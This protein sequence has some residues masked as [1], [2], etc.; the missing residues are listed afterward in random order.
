MLIDFSKAPTVIPEFFV[1][2]V[3][4]KRVAEHKYLGKV[5]DNKLNFN[6]NSDFIHK[7]CQTRIFCLLKLRSL[8]INAAVL[9]TFYRCCIESVLNIFVSVLVWRLE[10]E[11]QECLN[12]VVKVCGKVVGER[13]EH[14]SKLY[15]C[16]VVRKV[17]VIV[18]DNSHVLAK[19][20]EFLPS[21]RRFRVPKSNTVRN[22]SQQHF[23]TDKFVQIYNIV[24][25]GVVN[26]QPRFNFFDD[27]I[28]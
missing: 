6:K 10:Y 19:Y 28:K 8:N 25:C 1:D 24:Y 4:G 16:R 12:K 27:I 18:D 3:K 17:G 14:L 13:Q 20:Y 15:E 21:G 23:W 5:L 9:H 7:R 2:G 22:C 11:K 26:V